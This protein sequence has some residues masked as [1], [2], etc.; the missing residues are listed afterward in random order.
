VVILDVACFCVRF[1]PFAEQFGDNINFRANRNVKP[2]QIDRVSGKICLRKVH[3]P[4]ERVQIF[5]N[6]LEEGPVKMSHRQSITVPSFL[7]GK[8][9]VKRKLHS[10]VAV[11]KR[12]CLRSSPW[13]RPNNAPN[14]VAHRNSVIGLLIVITPEALIRAATVHPF[15]IYTWHST[16]QPLV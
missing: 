14:V 5:V 1:D 11:R 6:H 13:L 4:G 10:E 7:F 16:K 2:C 15:S 8:I 3:V 12:N 9:I